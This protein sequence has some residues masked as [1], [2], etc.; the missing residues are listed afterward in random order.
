[1]MRPHP[2]LTSL[3]L[4]L[5]LLPLAALA[6]DDDT[7]RLHLSAFS[8]QEV[9]N[10]LMQVT[11]QV[12]RSGEDTARLA[13][14]VRQIMD[15]ALQTGRQHPSVK[16]RTPAY[17]TQPVY[18]RHDNNTR[19]TGWRVIQTLE[20]ES[21]DLE[22]ATALV[23]KLQQGELRVIQMGFAVSEASREAARVSLTEAAIQGW[24]EKAASAARHMQASHWRPG[25]LHIQDEI[26]GP[27]VRPL[28]ARTMDAAMESAPAVQAG[29]SRLRVQVSGTALALGVESEPL[30]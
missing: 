20:L 8:E 4:C 5:S 18:E 27:P 2:L 3:I 6:D 12:E 22:S 11:L 13:R 25:E 23:G 9:D 29:T 1:P 17:T 19:Q 30:R 15:R 10:D 14:E 24:R 16:L 21:T 28:M 26:N 7:L